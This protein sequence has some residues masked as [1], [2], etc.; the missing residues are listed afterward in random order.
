M[1]LSLVAALASTFFWGVD[2]GPVS[3]TSTAVDSEASYRAALSAL[4]G[5]QAGPHTIEFTGDVV[6][7]GL[8]GGDAVYTGDQDLTILGNGFTLDLA[9]EGRGLYTTSVSLVTVRD[10]TITRGQGGNQPGG[11]CCAGLYVLG[12]QLDIFDSV[13]TDNWTAGNGDAAA[14]GAHTIRLIGST[15]TGNVAYDDNGGV[16]GV[17][18]DVIDSTISNNEARGYRGEGAGVIGYDVTVVN[19]TIVGNRLTSGAGGLG[20]GGIWA[21][22]SLTLDHATVVGNSAPAGK[23]DNVVVGESGVIGSMSSF[24]SVIAGGAANCDMRGGTTVSTYSYDD[25]GSCGFLGLGDTSNGTDPALAPLDDNGG[26]TQ[27]MLPDL[28]T[29]PLVDAVPAAD[30]TTV[31]DQRGVIRPQGSGCDIGAVEVEQNL[32]PLADPAGQY[33]VAVGESVGLDGTGSSDPDGDLLTYGWEAE[34]GSF[35][36][37]TSAL[38]L[39]LAPDTAG[40]YEI[41]LTVEDG[42][43]GVAGATTSVVVY[44]RSG[45]VTGVGRF[46]SEPGAFASDDSVEGT[47]R[48]GLVARYRRGH[49][50]PSG[51][52]SLRLRAGDLNFRSS[53]LDW[54]V[55]PGDDTAVLA[56]HGT[57]NRQG[58]YRFMIWAEDDRPDTFRIKIWTESGGVETVIYDNGPAQA[59]RSGIIFIHQGPRPW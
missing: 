36:D 34:A 27:T 25:D 38:P 28:A 47:A 5:D 12:G 30:C 7:D 23:A 16:T 35:D 48:L 42:R 59:L 15:V 50:T 41:T 57:V 8:G 52:F 32:P 6:F 37:A 26:T 56:G 20:G 3:A 11:A 46:H 22:G 13:L 10:L 58:D 19:S 39:F 21:R 1:R 24:A 31:I 14:A 2:A 53:G 18:V 33:L 4:S 49:D 44:D 40:I 55:V 45:F 51:M 29:S 43:G 9:R 54:L 17:V